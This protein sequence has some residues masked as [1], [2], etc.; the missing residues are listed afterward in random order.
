MAEKTG[1][2][3]NRHRSEQVVGTPQEFIDAVEVRFGMLNW[4]LACSPGNCK[5]ASGGWYSEQF[6]ALQES[7]TDRGL[8]W[9]NPPFNSIAKWARK[10]DEEAAHGARIIMLTPASISTNWFRDH[11]HNKAHVIPVQRM[12]FDGHNQ[13]FPKDLMLSIYWGGISGFG[14]RWDWKAEK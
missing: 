2:G 10:A 9:L 11:V 1:A 7:W 5:G 14:E 12:R 6:D 8:C 3:L 13:D 4:D